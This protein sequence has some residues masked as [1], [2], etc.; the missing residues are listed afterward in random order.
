MGVSS[1]R[2]RTRNQVIANTWF[3]YCAGGCF[4]PQLTRYFDL[5]LNLTDWQIGALMAVPLIGVMI[6]QPL[7]GLMADR[8][9]GLTQTYRLSLILSWLLLPV[10][11]FSYQI[12]GFSLLLV[13][14]FA[15]WCC[16]AATAPLNTAIIFSYL[17]ENGRQRFGRIRAF[18]SASF[19]F[20]V[21]CIGP[22]AVWLST[23]W[24]WYGRTLIFLV[25]SLCYFI[26]LVFTRW[27]K[28]H[29]ERHR[30]PGL[31]SFKR[32]IG[33]RNLLCLYTAVFCVMV[34]TASGLQYIGPYLG[35]LGYSEWFFSSVWLIGLVA[36]IILTFNLGPLAR[37]FGLKRMILFGFLAE[38]VR[39]LGYA[40]FNA[41]GSLLFFFIMHGPSTLGI[42]FA[43]SMYVDSECEKRVR[44]TAQS[45]LY[46]SITSGQVTGYLL[47]SALVESYHA[48]PRAEAMQ[49]SFFWSGTIALAAVVFCAI[50][51]K[52]ESK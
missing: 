32:L 5:D 36:E 13:S 38:A 29:F 3:M 11:A 25:G 49:A 10:F 40:H 16:Q 44:S 24:G 31:Q 30:R 23:Q 43:A 17:G 6:F 18:G 35:R 7:W 33:D 14:A 9:M 45:L 2:K 48:L 26:A 4:Y 42:F 8:V 19:T 34:G 39:W 28:Q 41:P 20:G 1:P 15:F 12:G 50:F 52:K 51:V 27:E 21:F 22:L 37:R 47:G 46:F